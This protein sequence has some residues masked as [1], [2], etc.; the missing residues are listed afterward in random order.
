MSDIHCNY[1]YKTYTCTFTIIWHLKYTNSD[2]YV[3]PKKSVTESTIASIATVRI[4][5]LSNG[6]WFVLGVKSTCRQA[7]GNLTVL[8]AVINIPTC[9]KLYQS[10]WSNSVNLLLCIISIT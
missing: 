1:N 4:I 2:H 5:L 3:N 10:E 6:W 8:Y 9:Y 7:Q